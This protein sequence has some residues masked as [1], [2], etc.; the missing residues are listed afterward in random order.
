[1]RRQQ[2]EQQFRQAHAEQD[3]LRRELAKATVVKQR[4]GNELKS[5]KTLPVVLK[6][7]QCHWAR[8]APQPLPDEE[9]DDDAFYPLPDEEDEE[10]EVYEEE[11]SLPPPPPKRPRHVAPT[12]KSKGLSK[13]ATGKAVRPAVAWQPKKKIVDEVGCAD[14]EDNWDDGEPIDDELRQHMELPV[15]EGCTRHWLE[16]VKLRACYHRNNGKYCRNVKGC[17]RTP[18][19]VYKVHSE[20][21][22]DFH[23]CQRCQNDHFHYETFSRSRAGKPIPHGRFCEKAPFFES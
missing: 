20:G 10:E 3:R 7:D 8:G 15:S 4:L 14:V 23:C 2:V 22:Y 13:G 6:R 5:D 11:L 21:N 16:L 12:P 1:M 18:G 17:C 9:D 19:C